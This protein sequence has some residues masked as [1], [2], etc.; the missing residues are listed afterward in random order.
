MVRANPVQ[1]AMVDWLVGELDRSE[2]APG[3]HEFRV[4]GASDDVMRVFFLAHA[5]AP[6]QV[7]EMATLLRSTADIQRL[8][9]YNA[10]KAVALRATGD[11]VALAAWLVD[12]LDQPDNRRDTAIHEY[13]LPS[14]AED[15]T[16]VFYIA[17][18]ATRQEL[19]EIASE[20]RRT[21]GI[22]RLFVYN[23]RNAVAARGSAEQIA[24]AQQVI[25][26]R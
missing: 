10:P 23:A 5:S 19:Q 12:E 1:V 7:Q 25:G 17:G 4:P 13:R 2:P 3:T 11:R 8:F 21:A 6:E 15:V 24:A 9:T 16:R 18:A 22:R 14:G 20:I 26:E